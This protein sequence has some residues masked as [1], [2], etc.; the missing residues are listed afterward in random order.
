MS[1]ILAAGYPF[2]VYFGLLRFGTR[3]VA[4]FLLVAVLLRGGLA[5]L[6]ALPATGSN[7]ERLR[8]LAVN[9]APVLLL[10][11][12]GGLT[13]NHRFLLALPVL[14]NVGM[15]AVFWRSLSGAASIVEEFARITDPDLSVAERRYCRTVTGVW[16]VFFA[17]NG[18]VSALL[19]LAAP[20]SWWTLYT[21][22]IA[23]LLVGA[24]F[25]VEFALRRFRFRRFRNGAVDRV[26]RR[27]Y[28]SSPREAGAGSDESWMSVR[29]KGS[30]FGVQLILFACRVCGRSFVRMAMRIVAAYYVAS[31]RNL[32]RISREFLHRVGMPVS[33]ASVYRHVRN[34]AYCATDRI[35]LLRGDTHLFDITRL[36]HE[37]V[38]RLRRERRGAIVIGAHFGS[39]EALRAAAEHDDVPLSIVAWFENTGISYAVYESLAPELA[40]RVI[41]LRPGQVD[42]LLE[43]RRR[44]QNG[45]LVAFLGDRVVPGGETVEVD[46]LGSPA[47]FPTGAFS[48][49]AA[50]GCPVLLIFNVYREPNRYELHCE[51]FAERIELPRRGAIEH[52]R[53]IVQRFATRLES[54]VRSAPE[55]WFNFYDFWS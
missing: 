32:R 5:A 22:F 26:L 21:G 45:E 10:I 30:A 7:R 51:P 13:A 18:L 11:V 9:F 34:F 38:E 48:V 15:L 33:L 40:A 55:N 43:V 41:P 47:R 37:H 25:A 23:Y 50:L 29:E 19:A 31:D 53:A 36:G 17:L 28:G 3:E 24:L 6:L 44:V 39:Y 20:I 16:C 14:V 12:A 4:L 49:A 2:L 54:H 46:F 42:H 27:L 35:F 1:V 52:K 8:K